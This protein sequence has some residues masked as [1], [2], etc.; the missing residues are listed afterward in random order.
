MADT[1]HRY[2]LAYDIKDAKRL[3]KVHKEILGYGWA[4][5]YS[6]FIADLDRIELLALK[7]A[8]GDVINHKEDTVAVIDLGAPQERGSRCFDFLG[9]RTPLPT[10]GAIII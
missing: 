9:R 2:L 6:V 7:Q 3:R 4:M 5:Q 8:L 10:S 1:R